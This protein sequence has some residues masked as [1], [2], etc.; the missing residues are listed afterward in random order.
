MTTNSDTISVPSC[1][2]PVVTPVTTTTT[3]T[4][5]APVLVAPIISVTKVPTLV[6]ANST[7]GLVQ[8]DYAVSNTGTVAMNNISVNDNKCSPMTYLSGNLNGN[9][10]MEVSEVWHYRCTANL[11]QTTSNTVTV[12][13]QANGFTATAMA[14]ATVVINPAPT[15]AAPAVVVIPPAPSVA[16]VVPILPRTG[17][18]PM[19]PNEF[20]QSLLQIFN[21]Y[22]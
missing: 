3:T 20:F 2:A 14:N 6:S 11:S 4:V 18:A 10:V 17:Y 1:S 9:S 21:R 15:P 8:Y 13:G 12:T 7:G 16:M 22:Y 19:E 5:A